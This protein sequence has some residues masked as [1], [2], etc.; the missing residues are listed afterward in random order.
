MPRLSPTAPRTNLSYRS[1]ARNCAI[2]SSDVSSTATPW[3]I[4]VAVL[5]LPNA[6]ISCAIAQ[7]FG[8]AHNH[9]AHVRQF[10]SRRR[11]PSGFPGSRPSRQVRCLELALR[12]CRS[13]SKSR[14][15]S[16]RTK[17]FVP[18]FDASVRLI[19]DE[20]AIQRLVHRLR[21]E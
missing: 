17:D 9:P 8:S 19:E 6:P 10:K 20:D 21:S 11:Q 7:E 3:V 12:R 15:V 1:L 13:H 4:V 16:A 18:S 2:C 14:Q 5:C